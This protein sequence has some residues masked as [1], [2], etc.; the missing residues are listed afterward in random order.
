M[1]LSEGSQDR[2]IVLGDPGGLSG[3][4]S[5][6]VTGQSQGRRCGNGC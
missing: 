3:I 2:G 5:V 6:L 4:T 1:G